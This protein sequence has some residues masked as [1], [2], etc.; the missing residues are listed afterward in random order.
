MKLKYKLLKRGVKPPIKEGHDD[1]TTHTAGINLYSTEKVR[2]NSGSVTRIPT[3]VAF[4]IPKGYFGMLK[5]RS[6]FAVRTGTVV[7]A[8]VIDSNYRGEIVVVMNNPTNMFV[9]VN[10]GE[11]IA[12]MVILPVPAVEL[13][14]VDNLEETVRGEKGFGSTE[15]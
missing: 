12:Q 2:L 11:G 3:G 8:G 9:D 14:E 6:G 4:Q 5:A 10:I 13:L 1:D 15:K 7:N